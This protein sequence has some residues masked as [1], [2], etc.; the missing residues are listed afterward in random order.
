MWTLDNIKECPCCY[1]WVLCSD[2]GGG[3]LQQTQQTQQTQNPE[4]P[5]HLHHTESKESKES[6]EQQR[7]DACSHGADLC[8]TCLQDYLRMQ[9]SG[10]A[11]GGSV[12]GTLPW[13]GIS[14]P[15]QCGFV[16]PDS[17]LPS[18]FLYKDNRCCI[19]GDPTTRQQDAAMLD[20]NQQE[21]QVLGRKM[22]AR[23]INAR[24]H[25]RFC[26][27][28]GCALEISSVGTRI[29][30]LLAGRW[31]SVVVTELI[32]GE[33]NT[34][35]TAGTAGGPKNNDTYRIEFQEGS[36]LKEKVLALSHIGSD[37]ES[38]SSPPAAAAAPFFFE[39]G[40][41]AS[42]SK[43]GSKFVKKEYVMYTSTSMTTSVVFQIQS[44]CTMTGLDQTLFRAEPLLYTLQSKEETDQEQQQQEEMKE[45]EEQAE[46][47]DDDEEGEGESK[48]EAKRKRKQ[49]RHVSRY[50]YSSP[51]RK[52]TTH[53]LK[54]PTKPSINRYPGNMPGT[55]DVKQWLPVSLESSTL[56]SVA[57]TAVAAAAATAAAAGDG[58][59]DDAGV[60]KANKN[61]ALVVAFMAELESRVFTE[62]ELSRL[63]RVS[64]LNLIRTKEEEQASGVPVD[65][66]ILLFQTLRAQHPSG[67]IH[68][69]RSAFN[70]Q[71]NDSSSSSSSNSNSN[72]N[73]NSDNQ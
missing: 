26:S 45:K 15:L 27:N 47:E 9:M 8:T 57:A 72:S 68:T 67:N 43:W 51:K 48:I 71:L 25:L 53:Q 11:D 50:A 10:D 38:P 66:N 32:P 19:E 60:V 7:Q 39:R 35:G 49:P 58:G 3:S 69:I 42:L 55:V 36:K 61:A 28:E 41:N 23:R 12:G 30:V 52:P 31:H 4:E 64:S 59:G 65:R 29:C 33:K 17:E 46:E 13:T 2:T 24:P 20:S 6:K 18:L 56:A 37:T 1:E 63:T 40:N 70:K 44:L 21:F 62:R 16:I 34:A 14:C 5:K 73:S 22:R 54:P